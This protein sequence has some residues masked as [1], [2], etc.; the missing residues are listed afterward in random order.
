MRLEC[1]A[2]ALTGTVLRMRLQETQCLL[3]RFGQQEA[4]GIG[5]RQVRRGDS[6]NGLAN[7]VAETNG[8]GCVQVLHTGARCR[9]IS[10]DQAR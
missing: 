10:V 9:D 1:Q 3:E 7:L 8:R 6:L 2:I 5:N 4:L